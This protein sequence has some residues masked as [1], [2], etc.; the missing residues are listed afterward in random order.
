MSHQ[1]K[2]VPLLVCAA[3]TS[4]AANR[5]A[6]SF[7][8]NF[9]HYSA[10]YESAREGRMFDEDGNALGF[11]LNLGAAI[12]PESVSVVVENMPS[13]YSEPDHLADASTKVAQP[14]PSETV[15]GGASVGL[16]GSADAPGGSSASPLSPPPPPPDPK[17]KEPPVTYLHASLAI[18][19]AWLI[20]SWKPELARKLVG[21]AWGLLGRALAALKAKKGRK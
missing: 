4:P 8:V 3:C 15:G 2:L 1:I 14:P 11:S 16:A 6:R 7:T 12:P 20:G 18:L 10:G 17:L 13:R 9:T 5:V 19:A 21:T